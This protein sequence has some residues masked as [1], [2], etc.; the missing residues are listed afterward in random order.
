M[1]LIHQGLTFAVSDLSFDDIIDKFNLGDENKYRV[2]IIATYYPDLDSDKSFKVVAFNTK[3]FNALKLLTHKI[4]LL[5]LKV[6]RR[7]AARKIKV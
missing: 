2:Q 4:K 3:T 7:R 5:E 1:F 6:T